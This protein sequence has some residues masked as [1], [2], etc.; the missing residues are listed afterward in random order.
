MQAEVNKFWRSWSQLACPKLFVRSKWHTAQR[1]VTVGDAVWLSDQNAL[2]GKYRLGRVIGT[3][4]DKKGI[5]RDV[6]VRIFPSYC[7]PLTRVLKGNIAHPKKKEKIHATLLH[8][9]VRQ[10]IVLLPAEEQME[11]KVSNQSL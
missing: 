2:R 4:P 8:R 3:N 6:N 5:V 7:I 10:L 11:R 1:N 9:D